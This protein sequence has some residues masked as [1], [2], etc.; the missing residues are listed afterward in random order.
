VGAGEAV[1][2]ERLLEVALPFFQPPRIVERLDALAAIDVDEAQLEG[3]GLHFTR[4]VTNVV[5]PAL[6]PPEHEF[7]IGSC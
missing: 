3:A 5:V 7:L 6:E 2:G 1:F 4:F